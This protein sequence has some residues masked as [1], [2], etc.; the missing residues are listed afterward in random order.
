MTFLQD[1]Y[2]LFL[3]IPVLLQILL[4][5]GIFVLVSLGRSCQLLMKTKPSNS[6]VGSATPSRAA[7]A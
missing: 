2:F 5:L 4:P 3:L 6:F 7:N 1:N